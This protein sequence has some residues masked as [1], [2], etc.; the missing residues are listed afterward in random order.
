MTRR[1]QTASAAAILVLI[2]AA[3][4][5]VYIL[6]LP[7]AD[8]EALLQTGGEGSTWANGG[9]AAGP[10]LILA[11]SPGTLR[12]LSS[13]ES[14]H[15]IPS[16][17]V[18]T[19][20]DTVAMKEVSSLRTKSSVF[21]K[22]RVDITFPGDSNANNY[23]L[24]FNVDEAQ[25][26]LIVL[27]NG[28]LVFNNIITERS[29]QPIILPADL[30]LMGDNVLTFM[31]GDVGLTFWKKNEYQLRNILVSA[32][33]TNYR[34]AQSEQH[35][36]VQD[37]EYI[38]LEKAVLEYVPD[39]DPREAGR[40]T[41]ES[42]RRLI[43][44]GYPDCGVLNKLD[45]SKEN[46]K[47]GDN[48]LTFVSEQ[49]S[50]LLDRIKVISNL[51]QEDYPITYFNLPL[52]LYEPIDYGDAELLLTLRFTD[53]RVE[54]RGEIV[55]NGFVQSFATQEFVYQAV[56]DPAILMPGPNTIQLIPNTNKLDVAEMR[57]EI[58]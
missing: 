50:Y 34:G 51:V 49:G 1:G 5:V 58:I 55:I 31:T 52:D 21:S 40:L 12:I 42:N 37:Q 54:K 8:R 10:V 26:N 39:C 43:Y 24:T 47:P 30:I 33:L 38:T 11:E 6:A 22:E 32:D 7:P 13:P 35:F 53:Y 46:L 23:L 17:T 16:T 28:Q 20:T 41:I 48:S 56:I 15:N 3:L 44:S 19:S 27:L 2:I 45:L 14:E 9:S 57:I 36:T 18:F 4:L 29:P 25:G